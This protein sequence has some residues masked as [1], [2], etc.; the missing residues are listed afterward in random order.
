[1]I[2]V[3]PIKLNKHTIQLERD[4]QSLYEPIHS[5]S[6]VELETLKTQIE[7]YLIIGFIQPSKSL[8]GAPISFDK[9]PDDSFY[10]FVDYQGLN[11]LT[12]KNKYPLHMIGKLLNQLRWE[13]KFTQLNLTSHFHQ[14]RIKEN[15]KSKIAFWTQYGHFKY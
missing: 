12:I 15:T 14:I 11:N 7:T 8:A 6:L 2:L 13:N 4:K 5:L 9:K 3:E 10:F 1:M